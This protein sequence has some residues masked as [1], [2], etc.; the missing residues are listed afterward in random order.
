MN[1]P[2]A[3]FGVLALLAFAMVIVQLMRWSKA[4]EEYLISER[5]ARSA[6]ADATELFRLR[7]AAETRIFGEPPA[8]DFIERVNHALATI[9]LPSSTAN[10]ITRE[11]DRGVTGLAANQRRRDM[12]IE[13]RPISTPDLG[14]FLA[15][16]NSENP[17]WSTRQITLRKSADRRAS[18]EDYHA[19][20]TLSAEYTQTSITAPPL[21]ASPQRS[22]TPNSRPTP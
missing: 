4:H 3:I 19:T 13:L 14:R 21:Q 20:L 2:I 17:A 12:R 5:A 7:T 15:A 1:R 10:S 8:E 6:T 22:Q 18:P 11:A 9:G 16:W